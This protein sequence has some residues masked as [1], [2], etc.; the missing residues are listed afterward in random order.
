MIGAELFYAEMLPAVAQQ[1]HAESFTI[2][3]YFVGQIALVAAGVLLALGYRHVRLL[4]KWAASKPSVSG[5][6]E[7]A[8]SASISILSG[9]YFVRLAVYWFG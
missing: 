9:A 6:K 7:L 1:G 3:S 2:L 4:I 5:D 8:L